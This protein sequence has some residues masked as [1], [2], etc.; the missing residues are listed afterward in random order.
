[1]TEFTMIYVEG[2]SQLSDL[3]PRTPGTPPSP[4]AESCF[5]RDWQLLLSKIYS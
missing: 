2:S 4:V 3:H 5:P 1:M